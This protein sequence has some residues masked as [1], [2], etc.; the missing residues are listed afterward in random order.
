M[1]WRNNF[2]ANLF[3]DTGQSHGVID[4]PYLFH[5]AAQCIIQ[6]WRRRHNFPQKS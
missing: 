3:H 1:L 2:E 6:I 4:K 5:D